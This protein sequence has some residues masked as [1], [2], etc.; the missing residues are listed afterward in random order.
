MTLES[1]KNLGGIGG[2][3]LIIGT[4]AFLVQSYSVV[5]N[6]VGII[7]VLIALHGLGDFYRER[8]V[9]NNGLAS[10]IMIVIG[11]GAA[12]GYMVYLFLYTNF[13]T[14]IVSVI[15]PGFNGDWAAIP[16]MT[17]NTNFNP[18]DLA[19]YFGTI[20]TIIAVVWVFAIIASVF[21]WRS[22]KRLSS[23][24]GVHLFSTAGILMLIGALLAV[25][26]IGLVLMWIAALL[27]TVAFFQI[28]RPIEQPVS[29]AGPPPPIPV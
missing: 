9:F 22:M 2:I 25:V 21:F 18:A 3:L 29:G 15:Y 23:S 12:I 1:S 4:L 7:L 16:G 17:P 27:M 24:S 6:F 5:V 10:F 8:S 20:L 11:V 13:F 19:P 28:K 14:G 26:V